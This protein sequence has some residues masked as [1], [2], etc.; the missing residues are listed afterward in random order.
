[1]GEDA[2]R[3]EHAEFAEFKVPAAHSGEMHK[4]QMD[5]GKGALKKERGKY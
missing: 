3:V 2:F 5:L 1:M 4:T